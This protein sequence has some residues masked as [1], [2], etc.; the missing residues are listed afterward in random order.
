[1]SWTSY[2]S[3]ETAASLVPP[4]FKVSGA[5]VGHFTSSL[6]WIIQEPALMQRVA[7]WLPD[8]ANAAV[9]S[10]VCAMALRL[11]R[12]V[13]S[14]EPFGDETPA[15]LV[16]CGGLLLGWG[17]L[18]STLWATLEAWLLDSPINPTT[19]LSMGEARFGINYFAWG[20]QLVGL[21]LVFSAGRELR[22]SL[23]E[24]I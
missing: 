8:L 18:G 3:P 1:M 9:V 4:V 12:R 21:A 14:G 19:I 6:V 7:V 24:V 17:L 22:E 11:A 10:T 20:A 23:D 15:T 13:R 2:V 16:R 5:A